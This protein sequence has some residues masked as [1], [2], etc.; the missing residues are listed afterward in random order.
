MP[1]AIELA[2]AHVRMLEPAE[3]LDRLGA[4][5]LALLSKGSASAVDRQRTLRSSIEW[6][7][8]LLD[9][10]ES[11]LL[12][13]LAVFD[14]GFTLAAAEA[15]CATNE[16]A[17]GE[18]FAVLGRLVDRSLV[19]RR[20]RGDT[21]RYWMLETIRKY[22]SEQLLAAAAVPPP[23]F[24]LTPE[25]D[26]WSVAGPAGSADRVKDAKGIRYL[27]RLIAQPGA[28]IHVLDLVASEPA[29]GGRRFDESA[30][31]V[32]DDQARRAYRDRL[33][34][35]AEDLE[36]AQS[37]NDLE[38]AARIDA[39]IEALKDQ[40]LA[41]AGLGDRTRQVGGSVE[42][43]RASATKAIRQAIDRIADRSPDFASHLAASVR[44]GTYCCYDPGEHPAV[45]LGED[46]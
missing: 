14:G 22:A 42:R 17:A 20:R 15:V 39:E 9:A 6:S 19:A 3:I 2:A 12:R 40:L 11:T 34:D 29:A 44:T 26:V 37:G 45:R 41:A 8:A 30:L 25:G 13:R 5:P 7:V 1:L 43:A 35:L 18:I 28:E 10:Q 24:T 4:D 27:A 21:T 16:L 31:P 33:R 38:R 36:E 46:L 32:L 23:G